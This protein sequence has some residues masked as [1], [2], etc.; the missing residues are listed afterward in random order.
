MQ[1]EKDSFEINYILCS[2]PE[3]SAIIY[4]VLRPF[5]LVVKE[6]RLKCKV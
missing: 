5:A 2:R 6:R 1:I 4:D 3:L